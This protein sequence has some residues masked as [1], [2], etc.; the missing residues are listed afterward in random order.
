MTNPNQNQPIKLNL[1]KGS[2][3]YKILKLLNAGVELD[4]MEA[5]KRVKCWSL[6]QRIGELVAMGVPIN[7]DEWGYNPITGKRYKIY[8]IEPQDRGIYR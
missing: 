5:L 8:K 3:K 7:R 2:Q 4:D 1:R 6:S